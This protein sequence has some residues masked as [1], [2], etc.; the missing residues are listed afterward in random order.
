MSNVER[1]TSHGVCT[2]A[3]GE[4]GTLMRRL[5]APRRW[6]S[7]AVRNGDLGRAHH[8]CTHIWPSNGAGN[9]SCS[10][11]PPLSTTVHNMDAPQQS[12][13]GRVVVPGTARVRSQLGPVGHGP[14]A[15]KHRALVDRGDDGATRVR[16]CRKDTTSGM[17]PSQCGV[18]GAE[19]DGSAFLDTAHPLSAI[20]SVK[21]MYAVLLVNQAHIP[22]RTRARLSV[23]R[24]D[25]RGTRR[26]R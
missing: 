23:A 6:P 11:C 16:P 20:P 26:A 10:T 13:S 2:A 14:A 5:L 1:R 12:K 24:S 9:T 18:G 19:L 8:D 22:T 25:A 3:L 17:A 21:S 4:V 15:W 7:R